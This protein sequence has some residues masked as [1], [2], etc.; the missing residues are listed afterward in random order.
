MNAILLPLLRCQRRHQSK[1]WLPA[2]HQTA[3]EISA[4]R[5]FV[6]PAASPGILIVG[7]DGGSREAENQAHAKADDD[8]TIRPVGEDVM[9]RPS[10]RGGAFAQFLRTHTFNEALE[11]LVAFSLHL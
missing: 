6:V 10:I 5:F 4:G 11:S 8:L 2:P 1:S 3:P 9:N 7:G